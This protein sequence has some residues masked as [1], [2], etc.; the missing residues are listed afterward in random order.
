MVVVAQLVR[1]PDC[2][3]GGRGFETHLPPRKV[4]SKELTFFY[5]LILMC[6]RNWVE[7]HALTDLRASGFMLCLE[8]NKKV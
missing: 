8:K 4:N 1:A 2:G 7:K 6:K 3:S 5:E